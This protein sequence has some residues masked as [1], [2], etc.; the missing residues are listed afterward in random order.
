MATKIRPLVFKIEEPEPFVMNASNAYK[1]DDK[2]SWQSPGYA[3]NY[4]NGGGK[5]LRITISEDLTDVPANYSL[6]YTTATSEYSGPYFIAEGAFPTTAGVYDVRIE[7]NP[8]SPGAG[9]ALGKYITL[10][11]A[12]SESRQ[13]DL[14]KI[15]LTILD[16]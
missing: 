15:T 13:T 2:A 6:L 1:S 11:F 12:N 10:I 3:D 7:A 5:T 16:P 4:Y 14:P 8:V 9:M